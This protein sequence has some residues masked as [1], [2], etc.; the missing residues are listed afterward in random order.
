VL[1]FGD[2]EPESAAAAPV[3]ASTPSIAATGP[4]A[5]KRTADRLTAGGTFSTARRRRGD[6]PA[7]QA[8]RGASPGV[9]SSC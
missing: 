2:L 3:R 5:R 9:R 7:D 8:G 1:P 4:G 6:A